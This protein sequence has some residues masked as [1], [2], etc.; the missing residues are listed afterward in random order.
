MS[1]YL[2]Q[3][4]EQKWQKYWEDNQSFKTGTDTSKPKYYVLEMFP[5]PS[6]RLHMGHVRNYTLGDVIARYKKAQGLNVLHPMGWDAFGLPAENAAMERKTHPKS[7]T[8]ENIATMRDQ[9]KSVGLAF[10]WSHEIATCDPTYYKHQQALFI[11]FYQ[12]GLAYRKESWVNWDPKENTV[13]ANEQVVDGKGWRSGVPIERR[14]LKQWFLKI[15]DFAD[16]LLEAID[17]LTEWPDRVRLMQQNWIGKSQGATIRFRIK[18]SKDTL[19][20]YT[21]RPDTLFGASFCAIAADHPLA[22]K[23]AETSPRL[24][25]F[26]KECRQIRTSERDIDTLD[27]V[28]Y[29]TGVKIM[30]PF[31]PHLELPLYVTN[32]VIMDY[33]L[34]AIYGCPAHDQRDF[35]FAKKYKLPILPVIKPKEGD[36]DYEKAPFLGEGSLTESDFLNGLS[37]EDAIKNTIEKL[38]SQH[39]G[40]GKTVYRL[41]DW[42]VSRQRYWGCPIPMIHCD[43]CGVQPVPLESLPV[44]LPEDVDFSQPGNPLDRHP[45]WKKTTCPN[46]AKPALRETDTLDTFFDSSWYFARFTSPNELDKPFSAE[47]V[48]YWLPVDQYIGGIEHAILHLLYARFFTRALK[49]CGFTEIEEPFKALMTQG[50]VCHQTYQDAQR[51]WLLPEEVRKEG[52]DY[53]TV[54]DGRPVTAG[55]IEKMSKSKKNVI[56]TEGMIASYGADATRLFMLSDSP[57]EKDIEWTTNGIDGAARYLNKLWL[58]VSDFIAQ[59]ADLTKP[60]QFTDKELE[61]RRLTHKTIKNVSQDIEKFKYNRAVALLREFSNGIEAKVSAS[62]NPWVIGEAFSTLLH[63]FHP[64]IPHITAELYGMLYPGTCLHDVDWPEYSAELVLD[65]E[66]TIAVQVNG[67]LRGTIVVPTTLSDDDIKDR[68]LS[69]ENVVKLLSGKPHKKIIYVPG[70]LVN[71]VQ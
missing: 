21:T 18:D 16:E 17:G 58:L 49:K 67:K 8:Y 66:I 56:D 20:V 42:G 29:D 30:H 13:L 65:S 54:S 10:D 1:R 2:F 41:R 24:A 40:K 39:Q 44:E 55:R 19:E 35:E 15:T 53:V 6:G 71:V 36:H 32:Y 34:G 33:G 50:M 70:R 23:L 26:Q 25:E 69:Q 28:G 5:Y 57:P 37:V 22:L 14:K 43:S 68:A 48:N 4:I 11:A 61:L 52:E 47:K 62:L 9:F 46:C 64:L 51:N 7:W 31:T 12:N 45:E 3:D 60:N 38:E 59:K 63:L 27:K